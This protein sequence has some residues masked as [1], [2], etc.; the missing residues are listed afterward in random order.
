[1]G[2]GFESQPDHSLA[3]NMQGFFIFRDFLFFTPSSLLFLSL[4]HMSN[5]FTNKVVAITGGTDGIGKALVNE[6]INRGAKV[7][8]CGRNP[9]KLYNLQ[10]ENAG[11]SLQTVYYYYHYYF[12]RH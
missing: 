6:L 4:I 10:V 3:V 1:M 7:A 12:R 8:T 2:P 5:S 11:K 9:D